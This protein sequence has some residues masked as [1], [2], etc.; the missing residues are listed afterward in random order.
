MTLFEHPSW[1]ALLPYLFVRKGKLGVNGARHRIEVQRGAPSWVFDI[2]T[3]C[4]YCKNEIQNVRVDARGGWTFN[5]SCPLEVSVKCARMP[6]TTAVCARIRDAINGRS[7][8]APPGSLFDA[9]S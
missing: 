1:S 9:E 8:A 6:V 4:A 3:T 5:V 2:R 7:P